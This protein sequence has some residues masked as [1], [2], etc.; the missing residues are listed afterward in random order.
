M[1]AG[2]SNA[3]QRI[4]RFEIFARNELVLFAY[5]NGKAGKVIFLIRHQ[6]GVLRRFTADKSTSCLHTAVCNALNDLLDLFRIIL[7]AGNIIEEEKRLCTAAGNIIH[8]HCNTVNSD[9]IVLIHK[10]GEF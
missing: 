7:S 5:S 10:K 6:T 3:D 8:T 9:G 1:N 2:R 4:T